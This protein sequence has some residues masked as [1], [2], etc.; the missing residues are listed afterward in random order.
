MWYVNLIFLCYETTMYVS[1]CYNKFN[2]LQEIHKNC[3]KHKKSSIFYKKNF[4]EVHLLQ[5]EMKKFKRSIHNH[6]Y[7]LAFWLFLAIFI[8]GFFIFIFKFIFGFCNWQNALS[9]TLD[10]IWLDVRM[11]LL[12]TAVFVSIVRVW[13]RILNFH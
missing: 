3:T 12:K 6:L 10:A 13:N 11:N 5:E 9:E 4:K 7:I 1:I 2:L 8:F